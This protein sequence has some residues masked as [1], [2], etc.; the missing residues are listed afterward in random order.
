MSVCFD[1]KEHLVVSHT[2]QKN[3]ITSKNKIVDAMLSQ[4]SRLG[5]EMHRQLFTTIYQMELIADGVTYTFSDDCPDESLKKIVTIIEK[6]DEIDFQAEYCF[7]WREGNAGPFKLAS[8]LE[9]LCEEELNGI[10]YSV[11][12]KADCDDGEG[13][14]AAFG[15]YNGRMHN[16]E[17]EFKELD[18]FPDGC[19]YAGMDWFVEQKFETD[20]IAEEV[21]NIC[22]ELN[23]L[24]VDGGDPV[25]GS[26]REVD[27]FLS[28][29]E[30]NSK[31]DF[32]KFYEGY[33]RIRS[34]GSEGGCLGDYSDTTGRDGRVMHIDY[35]NPGRPKILV[36]EIA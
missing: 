17:V 36:S 31:D 23:T 26:G 30:L 7:E 9:T 25:R 32:N 3:G 29:I 22:K 20:E 4:L 14:L 15:E 27:Y 6:A 24:C 2:E 33:A 1:I 34:F 35:D 16:G 18:S 19:W 5:T 12:S 28:N 21:R 10:F 13:T 11:W 8:V